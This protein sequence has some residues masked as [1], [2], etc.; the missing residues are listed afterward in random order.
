MSFFALWPVLFA[1]NVL[2][3]LKYDNTFINVLWKIQNTPSYSYLRIRLSTLLYVINVFMQK[4]AHIMIHNIFFSFT[5]QCIC[6]DRAL[7]RIFFGWGS[8]LQCFTLSDHGMSQLVGIFNFCN[9][10]GGINDYVDIHRLVTSVANFGE[11][12]FRLEIRHRGEYR[13]SGI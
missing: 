10:G 2:I 5:G 9:D 4:Y 6:T 1:K 3:L 13:S 8:F 11:A 7:S 12:G